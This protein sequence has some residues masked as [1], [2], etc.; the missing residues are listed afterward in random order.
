[1]SRVRSCRSRWAAGAI[2]TTFWCRR[3]MEQSRSYRCRMFP[4]WSPGEGGKL[5][6]AFPGIYTPPKCPYQPH[7][8][9][10]ASQCWLPAVQRLPGETPAPPRLQGP[11]ASSA[12]RA[13]FP[14]SSVL[15]AS[16]CDPTRTGPLSSCLQLPQAGRQDHS[17]KICTSMWRGFSM[18]FSTNSAPFP[19]AARASE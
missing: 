18:N 6:S 9:T 17:P 1:M 8:T 12:P 19:K 10:V 11:A 2:S 3:W 7:I 15:K 13:H 5:G 16:R 4:Y 14:E